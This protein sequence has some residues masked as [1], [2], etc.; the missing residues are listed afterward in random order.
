[1]RKI[2]YRFETIMLQ[3]LGIISTILPIK[4]RTAFGALLGN[5]MRLLSSKRKQITLD[6][7]KSSFPERAHSWHKKILKGSYKNLGITLAE[8]L[9]FKSFSREDFENYIK[10][11]NI[12]LIT[13]LLA[14]KRGVILLSGHYGNW[15]MLAYTAGL[16]TDLPV[17]IIV[18]KQRNKF[19]DT[20]MNKIRTRNG[21]NVVAMSKAARPIVKAV[22]EGKAIALLADQ[23]PSKDSDLVVDY[24]GK[25]TLTFDSPAAIALKFNVPIVMG[26]AERQKDGTYYVKLKEVKHDDLSDNEEGIRELTRRHVAALEEAVKKRPDLWAWQHRRW[27]HS[28]KTTETKK[29]DIEYNEK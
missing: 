17:L 22:R 19:V 4:T 6:N 10:Y 8:I 16:F 11:E 20:H 9:A 14:K 29:A 23:S 25:P 5:I 18:K 7:I 26:F 28:P 2:L 12:E 27:K 15:E 21:N 24:F 1:M 3:L 13:D